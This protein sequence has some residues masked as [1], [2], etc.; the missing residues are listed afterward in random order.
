MC[1]ILTGH[2]KTGKLGNLDYSGCSSHF[3]LLPQGAIR[4]ISL[5]CSLL[6]DLHTWIR[7][8]EK[9]PETYKTINEAI[10]LIL[11]NHGH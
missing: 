5:V 7:G 9:K 8:M 4:Y 1:S 10:K 2:Q 3:Y 6:I 11:I